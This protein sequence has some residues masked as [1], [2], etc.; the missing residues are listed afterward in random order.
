MSPLALEAA[1]NDPRRLCPMPAGPASLDGRRWTVRLAHGDAVIEAPRSLLARVS[2]ACNGVQSLR[3]IVDA[4]RPAALR[5]KVEA[6]VVD[7]L[8]SGV[9]VD[10]TLFTATAQRFAWI[11]SPFGNAAERAVWKQV[12]R[13]FVLATNDDGKRFGPPVSTPLDRFVSQRRS[14]LTYDERPL[15]EEDLLSYLWLLAGIVQPLNQQRPHAG[16]RRTTASGGAVHSLRPMLALRQAVG[17]WAPGVYEVQ[18]PAPRRVALVPVER[19]DGVNWLPRAV[20]HPW[21]LGFAAGMVFLVGDPRLGAIKYRA[22]AL[23]YM[24]IEAGAALQNAA[25]AAPAMGLAMSIYG[26]YLEQVVAEGLALSPNDVI[27]SSA[28]FG[29]APSADQERLAEQAVHL[30]FEWSNAPSPTYSTPYHVGRCQLMLG[31]E[32]Q[33]ES[34][35]R[36]ADPWLAYVKSAVESIERLAFR[37]PAKVRQA[38]IVEWDCAL[39][40]R[41]V[42]RYADAQ[43]R[44]REFPLKPF[45]DRKPCGWVQGRSLLTGRETAVLAEQVFAASSLRSQC[46]GA[47][48]EYTEANSSGCAAHVEP[49]Q[50]LEAA[51]LELV[52]RDAYMRAWLQQDPGAG[53]KLK[54]LPGAL[55][56]RIKALEARGC[57]VSLQQLASPWAPV[58]VVYAQHEALHFT[59]VGAAARRSVAAAA[60][61]ALDEM[62]TLAYFNLNQPGPRRVAPRGVKTPSDHAFL[63][64]SRH[65]FRR[66]DAVLVPS[67]DIGLAKASAASDIAECVSQRLLDRGC[68]LVVVDI[69]APGSSIDQGRTPV[70]VLRAL[71][72]ALVPMSFG[73]NR[74]PL[75]SLSRVDPRGRF[76]HPFP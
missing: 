23:Q 51:C 13:R 72:P 47:W 21:Y 54:S 74:E 27:V 26:G 17:R 50:A 44:S 61:S 24:F 2:M 46:P 56:R 40:P 70:S 71:V 62:E 48:A 28:I 52:E 11:P 1:F 57:R 55:Q 34:W 76:P 37:S 65:H 39:D 42:I 5:G 35:G 68:E 25:L 31:D 36:D 20:L 7:L 60:A 41:S 75:G 58:C 49:A 66:A 73:F 38:R 30:E 63:Y 9:L 4:T 59:V 33:V 8:R 15:R 12:P 69:A 32:M 45:D 64:T 53:L 6:F 29:A 67:T 19:S 3:E 16:P 43:Y 18:Y 22:R 10:A 14:V